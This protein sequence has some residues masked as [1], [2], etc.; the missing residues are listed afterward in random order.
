ML[1]QS[2]LSQFDGKCTLNFKKK[3]INEPNSNRISSRSKS[4]STN[5]SFKETT[6]ILRK[7]KT[8]D[9]SIHKNISEKAE[10]K[11]NKF[12]EKLKG[13]FVQQVR[14]TP[15][16]QNKE[17]FTLNSNETNKKAYENIIEKLKV[18]KQELEIENLKLRETIKEK[19][20]KIANLEEQAKNM[21]SLNHPK[22][23]NNA[24]RETQ[25]FD[26][27]CP[28]VVKS[29]EFENIPKVDKDSPEEP[30]QN[31]KAT[32]SSDS[33]NK[34]ITNSK[35]MVNNQNSP[36]SISMYQF[37]NEMLQLQVRNLEKQLYNI[38]FQ[39]S[40]KFSKPKVP[41]HANGSPQI[42][43]TGYLTIQ[44]FNSGGAGRMNPMGVSHFTHQM[45]NTN[46]QSMNNP[47]ATPH[48]QQFCYPY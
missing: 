25:G 39:M 27:I 15:N 21:D 7:L 47:T 1:K 12:R 17:A 41:S 33:S 20:A 13:E 44:N 10:E 43:N 2:K 23:E 35:K 28:K 48:P 26:Q 31:T 45:Q 36:A 22:E 32:E 29:I 42:K 14:N 4:T 34:F 5:T 24:E 9:S 46:Y 11:K 37:E 8:H 19:E 16:S 30:K 40:Q 6:E 18:E 3:Q 38:Q